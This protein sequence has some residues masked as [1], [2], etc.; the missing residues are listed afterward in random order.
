MI[1]LSYFLIAWTVLLA[2]FGFMTL[3]TLIQMLRHGLPSLTT[4]LTTFIFLLVTAGVII[5]TALYLSQ[6][7]LTVNITVVPSWLLSLFPSGT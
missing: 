7:D 1:P 4:Y 3:L 2:V 6:A 5:G